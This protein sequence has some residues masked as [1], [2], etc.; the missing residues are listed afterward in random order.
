MAKSVPPKPADTDA[1]SLMRLKLKRADERLDALHRQL[2]R[3][4]KR[5]P[6]VIVNKLDFHSGWYTSYIRKAEPL[7][8]RFAIPVGESLYHGRSVLDH[9]VWALVE[10]NG[11]TPGKQHEFPIL[12]GVSG[13]RKWERQKA[14]FIR[15]NGSGKLVGVHKDAI[16]VIERLQPYNRGNHPNYFL[17]ALNEMARDDRH[18]A[19]H[20]AR[21]M[22]ADPR[23]LVESSIRVPKGITITAF[24]P[25][26]KPG[27][28]LK[29]CTKLARFRVSRYRRKAE[30]GMET[31]LPVDVAIGERHVRLAEFKALN[32]HLRELLSLF[33]DFL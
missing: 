10:A 2:G 7:P 27:D 31:D 15:T 3:W 20:V 28:S 17:I 11:K 30:M 8:A 29:A 22:L 19:L 1:M 9:L 18:H 25:L 4:G 21:I 23:N 16:A 24:E 12:F 6:I 14:A 32:T 26:F 33:E 5:H 13:R